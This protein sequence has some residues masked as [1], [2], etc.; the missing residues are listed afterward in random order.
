MLNS[1]KAK[2]RMRQL[3]K[4]VEQFYREMFFVPAPN[5]I[6][7]YDTECIERIIDDITLFGA[8]KNLIQQLTNLD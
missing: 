6:N 4:Q 1:L 3:E 5:T 2:Y 8:D 7:L